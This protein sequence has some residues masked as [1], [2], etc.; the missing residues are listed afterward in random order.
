MELGWPTK[1]QPDVATPRTAWMHR[2]LDFAANTLVSQHLREG[3]S[4]A[5]NKV[6]VLHRCEDQHI[7]EWHTEVMIYGG[8]NNTPTEL[9]PGVCNLQRFP[10]VRFFERGDVPVSVEGFEPQAFRFGVRF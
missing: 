3:V 2:G 5:P 6:D 4:V 1:V 10:E 7:F 9:P 8:P